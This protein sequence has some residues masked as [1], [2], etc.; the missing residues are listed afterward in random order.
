MSI[1]TQETEKLMKTFFTIDLE[2]GLSNTIED[3]YK[4]FNEYLPVLLAHKFEELDQA[5]FNSPSRKDWKVVHKDV[6]RTLQCKFGPLT[7]KRRYY[8]HSESGEKLYLADVAAKIDKHDRLDKGLTLEL[9]T[10]AADNSYQ[11]SSKL[12]C[13]NRIS[14]QTVMK[15]TRDIHG[16]EIENKRVKEDVKEIHIQVDEDHVSMQNGKNSIVK[17]AVVHEPRKQFKKKGFL[18]NKFHAASYKLN[19]VAFWSDLGIKIAEMYGDREDLQVYIHGDGASWIKT[20][21][22]WIPNSK[23]ILDKYHLSKYINRLNLPKAISSTWKL[24]RIEDYHGIKMLIDTLVVNKE[25]TEETGE[26]L[27]KYL[28]NNREGIKNLLTL[29]EDSS[30]SCAEGLVSHVLSDRLSR[31]P[32]G[33]GK[34][35]LE[36]ITQTRM[37]L[38]NGGKLEEKHLYKPNPSVEKHTEKINEMKMRNTS[39]TFYANFDIDKYVTKRDERRFFNSLAHL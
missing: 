19:S 3:L 26:G 22:E 21:L 37:Y 11:K 1:I 6:P 20:G 38:L 4:A 15:K 36:T 34:E 32:L 12:A 5:L 18:P 31:K 30:K 10:L 2:E 27:Y 25:I 16:L 8:E 24:L 29:P 35:G 14:R 9:V 17:L 7:Y 23:Y 13:N 33:W 39:P 28:R